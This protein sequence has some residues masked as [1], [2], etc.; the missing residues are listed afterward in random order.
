MHL[1]VP[2]SLLQN[3]RKLARHVLHKNKRLVLSILQ[4]VYCFAL[5]CFQAAPK[6]LKLNEPH[7]TRLDLNVPPASVVLSG[8]ILHTALG[9]NRRL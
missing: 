3:R 4:F 7:G 9:H 6:G 8:L 1:S 2:A 5:V